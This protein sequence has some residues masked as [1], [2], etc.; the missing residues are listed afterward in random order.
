MDPKLVAAAAEAQERFGD[1]ELEEF[2]AKLRASGKT[3][4]IYPGHDT[5]LA[6]LVED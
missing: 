1:D 4:Q 6:E 5:D 3:P 2:A